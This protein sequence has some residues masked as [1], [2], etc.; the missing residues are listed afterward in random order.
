VSLVRRNI[1][2]VS[3]SAV[4]A[5]HTVR[6]LAFVLSALCVVFAAGAMAF[7]PARRGTAVELGGGVAT[8]GIVLVVAYSVVRSIAIDHVDGAE[9]RAAAGAVWDAF[10][11]D[12]RTL[13]WIVAGS[14]AV[15]AAAAAS[16]IKPVG[17][18]EPVRRAA[19]W[20]ATEPRR[21]ALRSLR[22]VGFVV[23]GVV[24][25]VDRDAVLA[26]VLTLIGVYL[27]YEGV[28]ALLRLVY[29]PEGA[30]QERARGRRAAS[31]A[32]R[33]ALT[34]GALATVVIVG[35]ASAF[36][37]TGGTATPAPASA[38]CDG[39][40][41]LCDRPL[42]QVALA[43]THNAMSVPLPGW[44]SSE[45]EK[46]IA[47][48]LSAGIR[49]LLVDAH[50]ADRLSNG[51]LRTDFASHAELVRQAKE[52]G[53][54]A[55]AVD[56]AL[57]I[58]ERLGFAG[59]GPRGIYLC[60]TFCEL[61]AT[62]LGS[63]LDD[64]HDFLVANPGDVLVVIN[65]DYVSPDDFVKAVND[66]K[67]ASLAYAGPITDTQPT[68][69]RMIDADKRVVF[70]AENHAGAAPWYRPA[71]Q[72]I[73]EETP[74]TFK[75]VAQLTDPARLPASC[76]P[77]RGPARAPLFLV[78]HWI[79]TDPVPLLSDAAKVNAYKPLLARMRECR[80]IRH[81]LPNLV[82]V[83]FYG[84]GDVFRVVNALNGVG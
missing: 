45:Q 13:A 65:Q 58:R 51:K 82:A 24:V 60:H 69:R 28:T 21:P 25:I 12:L 8:A 40:D 46:P 31:L 43:A 35:A 76:E 80:R 33:R 37:G 26:F 50:Y 53:L 17:L 47:D 1:S 59:Q 48:Q 67:L 68:L 61:G 27:V 71:Y 32:G 22:A 70:L 83:N 64:I 62:T 30:E 66:A 72:S 75:K 42:A 52:E 9:N 54:S 74:Y 18:G 16:V 7:S 15:V 84:T 77:N 3:A 19:A 44:Y 5:A 10:F 41:E 57:R 4:G 29:V 23:L 36:V 81:H 39:H 2:D 63:V 49:G 20:A 79:S 6:V 38:P 78:N 56:A 34:A 11:G 55:E 14:G 73:T